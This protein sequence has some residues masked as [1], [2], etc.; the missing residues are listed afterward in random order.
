MNTC[1]DCKQGYTRDGFA[2]YPDHIELCAK[3]AIF[4]ELLKVAKLVL[5]VRNPFYS[6]AISENEADDKLQTVIAKT[7][8]K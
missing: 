1:K 7:K 5:E 6:G 3:H 4:D 8:V 2:A